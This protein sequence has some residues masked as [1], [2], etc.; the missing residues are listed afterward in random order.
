MSDVSGL[1]TSSYNS[2]SDYG[3]FASGSKINSAADGAAESA[4]LEKE[5]AQ[6]NGYQA[7]TNNIQSGKEVLNITDSALGSI[8]DYLQR[9]RELALD[10]SNTAIYTDEDRASMQDEIEQMKQGIADVASN[11]SYNT[12]PLLDGSNMGMN[13]ATDANGS[14]TVVST[15]NATLEALG[16]ADFD[17]TGAFD[18]K[19]IDDAIQTVSAGRSSV[20]AQSNALD[21]AMNYNSNTME[22]LTAAKSTL[23]DLDYPQAISDQKKKETLQ[24]YTLMMQR[25]QQENEEQKVSMMYR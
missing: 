15:P 24:L 25:K 14:G 12:L 18:L 9:I 17:V 22:N 11:T 16:I 1:G 5:N 4:I 10:A 20:G 6:I 21:Y 13:I 23:E 3:K 7:G 19:T 8:N 2:Y